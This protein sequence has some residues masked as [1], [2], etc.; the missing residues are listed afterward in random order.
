MSTII[1]LE[2]GLPFCFPNAL[3]YS[4]FAFDVKHIPGTKNNAAESLDEGRDPRMDLVAT[5]LT[6]LSQR[7]IQLQP[8]L[9]TSLDSTALLLGSTSDEAE[10]S[11]DNPILNDIWKH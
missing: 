6:P 3:A 11:G 4:L 10:Y 1:H 8:P 2:M 9:H 7:L 5:Q